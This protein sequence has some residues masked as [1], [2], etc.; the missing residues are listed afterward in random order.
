[1]KNKGKRYYKMQTSPPHP[2]EKW[3]HN[4]W[5]TVLYRYSSLILHGLVSQEARSAEHVRC[6][7]DE[8]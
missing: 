2:D 1:M 7:A 3:I 4:T 6:K 8:P 5:P